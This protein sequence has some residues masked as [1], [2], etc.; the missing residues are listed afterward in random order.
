MEILVNHISIIFS[1]SFRFKVLLFYLYNF[2]NSEIMYFRGRGKE[3][4]SHK[5]NMRCCELT[6]DIYCH[7]GMEM[8]LE[9]EM[10]M[11]MINFQPFIFPK[12]FLEWIYHCGFLDKKLEFW[13]FVNK[14][15]LCLFVVLAL[16]KSN[17][18]NLL[19]YISYPLFYFSILT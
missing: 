17:G 8:G 9:W 15:L 5:N 2:A 1:N 3:F 4:Y 18:R 14:L 13:C 11:W 7:M 6:S 16:R 12:Q 10:W 19:L